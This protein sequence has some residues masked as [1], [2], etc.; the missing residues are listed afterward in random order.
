MLRRSMMTKVFVLA[1]SMVLTGFTTNSSA[2]EKKESIKIGVTYEQTGFN[3]VQGR[4]FLRGIMAY[5]HKINKEGGILGKPVESIVIDD[6]SS[7]EQAVKNA[8]DLIHA[9]KVDVII[10]GIN[11]ASSLGVSQVGKA[12]KVPIFVNGTAEPIIMEKGHRYVFRMVFSSLAQSYGCAWYIN[13]HWPDK[14]K[15]YIFGSDFVYG[16]TASADFLKYVNKFNPKAVVV[17]ES[18]IK[19]GEIDYTSYIARLRSAKPDV[20][21]TPIAASTTFWKQ[22]KAAGLFDEVQVITPTWA[23]NELVSLPKTDVPQGMVM[24]GTP[25]YWI[26]NPENTVFVN[27][28]KELYKEPPTSCEYF[29]YINTMFVLEGIKKA[30]TTEKEKIVNALEGL[31]LNTPVGNVTIRQF[32]HQST[33]PYY[34]GRVTWSDKYGYA[35]LEEIERIRVEDSLPTQAEVEAARKKGN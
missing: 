6:K 19:M 30:Q 27:L 12:E 13:K 35:I 11:S 14:K 29:G 21:F 31:T 20:A 17:G 16:R 9:Q 10:Q 18:W 3:G 8:R 1:V 15:I 23:I 32:D 33:Y 28:I 34:L 2:Q 26:D 22:G 4:L 25:W 5:V 24:D 7:P